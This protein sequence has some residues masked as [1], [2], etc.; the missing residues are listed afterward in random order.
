MYF[1][2]STGTLAKYHLVFNVYKVHLNIC[3]KTHGYGH[4]VMDTLSF[5]KISVISQRIQLLDKLDL[6]LNLLV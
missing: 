5:P 4:T 1:E 3:Y 2:L 6:L